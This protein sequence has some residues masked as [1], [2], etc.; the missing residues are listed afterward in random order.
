MNREMIAG[1]AFVARALLVDIP[2]L[3]AVQRAA[4][5]MEAD[6]Y[7]ACNVEPLRQ[8]IEQLREEFP[9]LVVLK[10]VLDGRIAGS[11]RADM[12]GAVCRVA[13]LAVLPEY[14]GRGIGRA[15]LERIE[16]AFPDAGRYRLATGARSGRNLRL[17]GRAG[18]RE[19][20]RR[21]VNA[22]LELIVLEKENP[23][24]STS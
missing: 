17:Y 11:I 16:A 3:L 7:G 20:S 24:G 9:Q 6:V 19:V 23:R 14:Q 22:A 21:S 1:G 2:E 13:K 8:T 18:Y 12:D 5:A 4:F 15:L 10:A